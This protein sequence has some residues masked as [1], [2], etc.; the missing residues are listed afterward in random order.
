MRIFK[1]KAFDKFAQKNRISDREL[2][3]AITR[4]EAGL[5]DADLGGNIIKQRLSGNQQGRRGGY[6]SFIFYR[7]NENCYFV[8]GISK[9]QRDNIT[10][11]ELSALK[12]LAQE[13]LKLTTQQILMQIK[14]GYFIEI[15][16]EVTNE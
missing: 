11:K 6:R 1:T 8:A 13:Y 16:P 2:Y 15:F 10:A 7:I 4:A 3:E 5:I 14:R 12:E 9:N